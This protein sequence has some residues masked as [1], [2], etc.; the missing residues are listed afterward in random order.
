MHYLAL[1]EES[2]GVEHIGVVNKAQD[3]VVGSACLLLCG[4]CKSA[5]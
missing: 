1:S 5:T 2:D 4:D 3:V